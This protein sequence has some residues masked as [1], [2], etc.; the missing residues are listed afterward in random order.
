MIY[1]MVVN[2]K[3]AEAL[4]AGARYTNASTDAVPGLI[5]IR[6]IGEGRGFRAGDGVLDHVDDA[7]QGTGF[8]RVHI[9]GVRRPGSGYGT[10]LYTALATADFMIA[11]GLLPARQEIYDML[12]ATGG[13]SSYKEGRS[14]DANVWWKRAEERGLV[15]HMMYHV[16]SIIQIDSKMDRGQS[17]VDYAT[18]RL[19]R[20]GWRDVRLDSAFVSWAADGTGRIQRQADIFLYPRAVAAHLVLARCNRPTPEALYLHETN[21]RDWTVVDQAAWAAMS[22]SSLSLLLLLPTRTQPLEQHPLQPT[23]SPA[24]TR[25][26]LHMMHASRHGMLQRQP[27]SL[28]R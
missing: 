20:D 21:P 28:G 23:S 12:H 13:V 22:V 25:V 6:D 27:R 16:Q 17:A 7:S 15:D 10:G 14:A 5:Y 24:R 26:E 4:V 8:L 1:G 18:S 19:E 9:Y 2:P 11:N 3:S